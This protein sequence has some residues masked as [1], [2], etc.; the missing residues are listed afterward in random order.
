MHLAFVGHSDE[1][2]IDLSHL[3]AV[4][5]DLM[6]GIVAAVAEEGTRL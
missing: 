1:K 6:V 4:P 5:L 2:L 3:V